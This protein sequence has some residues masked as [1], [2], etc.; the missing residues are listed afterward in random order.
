MMCLHAAPGTDA[1]TH[2]C[3]GYFGMSLSVVDKTHAFASL[4]NSDTQES[5]IAAYD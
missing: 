4:V 5:G 1:R 2:V 3:A